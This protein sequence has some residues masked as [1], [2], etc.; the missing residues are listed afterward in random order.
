LNRFSTVKLMISGMTISACS[1]ILLAVPPEWYFII[2]GVE[3]IG[4]A[5][6]VAIVAQIIVFA[7]GELLFSPRFS[8]YVARVAPKDKVA[9]YMSLSALPMF[10]AKPINGVVGG[11]LVSYYCYDGIA[12]KM[13]TGH[14]DFWN[15][16][17]FMWTI[18]MIMAFISPIAIILT[19]DSFVSDKPEEDA[20]DV[21]TS[22]ASEEEAAPQNA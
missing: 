4:Q 12:A 8:E 2:P 16:P 21:V 15:S 20:G 17:E 1:M 11:L 14:V 13:D 10:I 3:T 19:K 18:Y 5:Y 6:F 22:D 7:S 9:S